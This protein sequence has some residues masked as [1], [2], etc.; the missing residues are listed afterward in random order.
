MKIDCDVIRDLLPLY[1]ED[2]VSK[3]SRELVEEHCK[4]CDECSYMLKVMKD[5]EIVIEDT[6]NGLK[7]FMKDCKK[8]LNA[9]LAVYCYILL[10]IIAVIHGK[11]AVQDLMGA[12]FLYVLMLFPIVGFFCNIAIASQK[13]SLKYLF[14]IVCGLVGMCYQDIILGSS[15]IEINAFMFNVNFIPALIGFAIGIIRARYGNKKYRKIN[16]G[17]I[18]GIVILILSVVLAIYAPASFYLDIVIGI[19]AIVIFVVSLLFN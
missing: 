9:L 14:P 12:V 4:E 18:A 19:G 1:V 13:L 10:V 6:G 11:C 7:K 16:E 17:M 3:K 8:S 5:D 15:E 2:I